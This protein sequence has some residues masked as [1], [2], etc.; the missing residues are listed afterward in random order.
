MNPTEVFV[1]HCIVKTLALCHYNLRELVILSPYRSQVA[2]IK[3][4]LQDMPTVASICEV[5]TIDKYQ[6]RDTDFVIVSTVRSNSSLAPGELLR[7]WRRINV[8][9]TRYDAYLCCYCGLSSTRSRC[10]LIILGSV[11][12][13]KTLP[14]L[15][16]LVTL[17]NDRNWIIE[18][19][20]EGFNFS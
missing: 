11:A 4:S 10:K 1:V 18:L 13:L 9:I 5:S 15:N 2:A 20:Q 7:D 6:G 16:G 17:L 8:A 3:R 19:P 12:L 14:L